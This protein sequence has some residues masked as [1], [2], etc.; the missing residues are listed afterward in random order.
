M[1]TRLLILLMATSLLAACTGDTADTGLPQ[2]AHVHSLGV[3]PDRELLLGL[4]G[5]LFA[6]ADGATWTTA[7]LSG[8]DAMVI[9]AAA[10]T[11]VFVAGHDVLYRSGDGGA[12]FQALNPADLPGLDIHAFAQA[13]ANG[14]VLYAYVVGHGLFH[15]SDAGD[16][17][18]QR[19][20]MGDLPSDLLGLAVAD[21]DGEQ[22]ILVGPNNG[23][24]HSHDGGRTLTRVVAVGAW[25]VTV[26]S[27][28]GNRLWALTATG[29]M[30][31]DDPAADWTQVSPLSDLEGQPVALAVHGD[32]IWIVTEDPRTLLRSDDAGQSWHQIS[33]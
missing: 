26:D 25:T 23:I 22:L 5:G 15:S 17:W 1:K 2:G 3:T 27:G 10:G 21:G 32:T 18:E 31:S 9:A 14:A 12:T 24:V 33:G 6:S 28:A 19:A 8:E 16:T 20:S 7:G 4:H 30:A 29:L 13:P 11:P